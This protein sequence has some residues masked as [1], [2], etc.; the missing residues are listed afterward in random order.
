LNIGNVAVFGLH[1]FSCLNLAV[2]RISYDYIRAMTRRARRQ[3]K[4][5]QAMCMPWAIDSVS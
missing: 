4:T 2:N 3:L 5:K 1:G